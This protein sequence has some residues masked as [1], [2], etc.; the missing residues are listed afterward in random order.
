MIDDPE[1]PDGNECPGIP[2]GP[3]GHEGHEVL[4]GIAVSICSTS[5]SLFIVVSLGIHCMFEIYP[6][7][8][9]EGGV[10]GLKT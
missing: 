7:N 1:G 5:T 4:D 3:G 8:G 10:D 2:D 9:H 6:Q